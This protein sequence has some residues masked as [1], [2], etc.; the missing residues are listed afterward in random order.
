M[1]QGV[2]TAWPSLYHCTASKTSPAV[3]VSG[4]KLP[5]S[6][7][8]T[9]TDTKHF[10]PAYGPLN[11]LVEVAQLKGWAVLQVTGR[12]A[13]HVGLKKHLITLATSPTS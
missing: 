12:P 11:F 2:P 8:V 10:V 7:P 3:S 1:P 5:S 9:G 6:F 4:G 13:E